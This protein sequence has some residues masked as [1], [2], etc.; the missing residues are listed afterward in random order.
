[1]MIRAVVLAAGLGTRMK[2]EQPKMLHPLGGRPMFHYALEAARSATGTRPI[3]I[4]GHGA[5]AL[6]AEVGS[7]AECILQPELLGTADA[8]RRSESALRGK[9]DLVL[10]TYGDMPLLRATTLRRLIEAM[11]AHRGPLGMLTGRDANARGFGRI[12][13]DAQGAVQA[14]VEES[15][16]SADERSLLDI[17]PG[18]YVARESWLWPALAKVRPSPKGEY[19]LT[20]LV[21]MAAKAGGVLEVAIDDPQEWIGVNT[22]AHLA[23]A[24]AALRA[25]INLAWMEAGVTMIDPATTYIQAAVEIGADTMILPN[26][27]LEGATRIGRGCQIGP[28]ATLRD[29]TLGDRCRVQVAIVEG[30]RLADEVTVGPFAHLRKGAVLERGVH[31]G[32]F[33]EIKNSTLGPGTKMGHFSYVGDA[34]IG[35]DVNIGAGT[36]TCNFDGQKKNP[37]AIGDGAFIGSDTMLVAPVKIGRG[38]RTGAGAVVTRDV[39]DYTL[40]VGMPARGI[41]KLA[42]AK[43]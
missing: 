39:P 19:Y 35:A 11:D 2:S 41:R 30:A 36:I 32:N 15:E 16:A 38:A 37:T 43:E 9:A 20:D 10:V 6:Q 24:E 1:M 25:R 28:D 40:A 31:M 34:T 4:I 22:R 23:E 7:A 17:N 26:T 12:V 21:E 13:R 42:P 29:A 18:V 3:L 14:V 8:V 27:R 33:G 5:E